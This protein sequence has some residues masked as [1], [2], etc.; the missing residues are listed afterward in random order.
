MHNA[1]AHQLLTDAPP[2]QS[3]SSSSP[4]ASCPSFKA[5]TGQHMVQDIPPATV[6]QLSQFCAPP[7]LWGS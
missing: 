5:F 7:A 3:S 4:P 2:V 6:G 1:V